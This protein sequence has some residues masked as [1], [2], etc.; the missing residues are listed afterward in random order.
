MMYINAYHLHDPVERILAGLIAGLE[1]AV[2]ELHA[3]ILE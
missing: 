1:A 2:G 3:V